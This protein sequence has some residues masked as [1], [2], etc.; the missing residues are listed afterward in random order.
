MVRVNIIDPACLADQHLVAEYDEILMLLGYVRRYPER[1][2]ARGGIPNRYCLGKGH[3]MFFKDKLVY[4][5]RRHELLKAEMRKR[6]FRPTKTIDLG[7]F[8]PA[9]R[10]DW[11]PYE[12]D[13]KIIR[14][15]IIE[16]LRKKQGYYRYHGEVRSTGF[17]VGL[18][19]KS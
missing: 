4:L 11:T 15:R 10:N 19:C 17:L 8:P 14:A 2:S 9:L 5:K 13:K 7:E 18:I 1:D 6:G 16:K 3:I 12:E